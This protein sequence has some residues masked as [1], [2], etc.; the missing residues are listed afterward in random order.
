MWNLLGIL[1]LSLPP[2]HPHSGLFLKKPKRI[3]NILLHATLLVFEN[4][5][6]QIQV[7]A[8]LKIKKCK[9]VHITTLYKNFTNL[10]SLTSEKKPMSSPCLLLCPQLMKLFYSSQFWL[11]WPHCPLTLFPAF[12][13]SQFSHMIFPAWEAISPTLEVLSNLCFF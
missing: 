7:L 1:P 5:P 2:P 13:P 6:N 11:Q 9:Y 3:V 8:L 12:L 4:K 10:F